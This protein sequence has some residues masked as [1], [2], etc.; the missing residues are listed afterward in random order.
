MAD[1]PPSSVKGLTADETYLL[2]QY[3]DA[4]TGLQR[5]AYRC[6]LQGRSKVAGE[7]REMADRLE[8]LI[9]KAMK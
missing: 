9:G 6:S 2:C 3:P 4:I 8:G 5:L 7:V 1:L